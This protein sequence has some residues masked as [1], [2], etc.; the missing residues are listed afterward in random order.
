MTNIFDNGALCQNCFAPLDFT[1]TQNGYIICPYCNS[2]WASPEKQVGVKMADF[3][4]MVNIFSSSAVV[5]SILHTSDSAT[6]INI[7]P[8][9]SR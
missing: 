3:S 9:N 4:R 6:E 2:K 5:P 1:I 7:K 8:F